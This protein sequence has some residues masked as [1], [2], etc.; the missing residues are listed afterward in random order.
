MS[1]L[2]LFIVVVAGG[3][4]IDV[5]MHIMVRHASD[6]G[7]IHFIAFMLAFFGLRELRHALARALRWD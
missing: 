5:L 3:L 1:F 4:G 2:F 7:L 6:G